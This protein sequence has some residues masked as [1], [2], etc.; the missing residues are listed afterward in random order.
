MSLRPFLTPLGLDTY[1]KIFEDEEI[2]DVALLRSMGPEMLRESM[3]E[4]SRAPEHI[5]VLEK[6]LF[7]S[8]PAE[9]APAVG[10]TEPSLHSFLAPLGLQTYL[11]TFEDEEITDVA[12][13]RSGSG[14]AR[15]SRKSCR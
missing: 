10:A 5:N 9:A 1:L 3:E 6:A 2:T 12:L 7:A 4:L 14:N 13:L 11:K 15:E 8:A